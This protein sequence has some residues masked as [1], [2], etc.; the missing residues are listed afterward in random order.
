MAESGDEAS[1]EW[2]TVSALARARGVNKAAIS[3]RVTRLE[4]AGVLATRPGTRGTKLIAIAEFDLACAQTTDAIRE[5]NG[6]A[7][8]LVHR[9][10][11]EANVRGRAAHPV[12]QTDM[13]DAPGLAREQ[14]RRTKI[15]ADTAQLQFDALKGELVRIS[16]FSDRVTVQGDTLARVID[17]LPDEADALAR[18]EVMN[19]SAFDGHDAARPPGRAIVLQDLG[20]Q[21]AGSDR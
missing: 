7:A 5:A 3:R 18:V 9:I 21:S 4:A 2:I 17:R 11:A 8:S 19:G 20:A 12:A 14:A 6:R 15:A 16:D 10:A 13:G 1:G